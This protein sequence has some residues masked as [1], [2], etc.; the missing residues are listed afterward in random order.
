MP[1]SYGIP[2]LGEPNRPLR[3]SFYRSASPRPTHQCRPRPRRFLSNPR[4]VNRM[5]ILLWESG[6]RPVSRHQVRYSV[7]SSPAMIMAS[8]AT[9]P[10][11]ETKAAAESEAEPGSGAGSKLRGKGSTIDR[12][13][14]VPKAA[15]GAGPA[16]EEKRGK[17]H[18]R[19]PPARVRQSGWSR[20]IHHPPPCPRAQSSTRSE[21]AERG[22]LP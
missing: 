9:T 2:C 5:P 4:S 18:R 11:A 3:Q 21:N 16:T 12:G 17:V 22:V 20:T 7:Y 19:K 13:R 8:G 14:F 1:C 6:S 15:A 10:Q